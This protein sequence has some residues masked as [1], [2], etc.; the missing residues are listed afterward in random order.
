M[1]LRSNP[2][3][4]YLATGSTDMRKSINGLSILVAD[5]LEHNPLSGAYFCFCNKARSIIKI[6]YFER[7]GF[8]IWMKRLEKD[9]F[10]WPET[11]EEVIGI[12][13]HEL[14]WL[15]DGLSLEQSE[16]HGHLSYETV[17]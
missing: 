13:H 10:R 4:V 12:E 14:F 9:R 15:L 7:N 2:S 5:Q 17:I 11:E 8:C 3:Q 1:L 6:L 16:A